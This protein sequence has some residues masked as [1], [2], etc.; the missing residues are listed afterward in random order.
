MS[1]HEI[2][3]EVKSSGSGS[4]RGTL[5]I[6]ENP[7]Q[8]P[9]FA[10]GFQFVKEQK[11]REYIRLAIIALTIIA[12]IPICCIAFRIY[13]E[14]SGSGN[15]LWLVDTVKILFIFFTVIFAI[16]LVALGIFRN[17]ILDLL[18]EVEEVCLFGRD[19]ALF[20]LPIYREQLIQLREKLKGN[21]EEEAMSGLDFIKDLAPVVKLLM[22]KEK[23]LF[24]WGVSGFKMFKKLK[25]FMEG[26]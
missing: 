22:A 15:G 26:K 19:F 16:T 1:S 24:K 8:F 2:T 4:K 3:T 18:I 12:L 9:K 13:L 20:N 25:T 14:F 10:S 6:S 7:E 23:S 5:V 11:H 21:E 17:Q